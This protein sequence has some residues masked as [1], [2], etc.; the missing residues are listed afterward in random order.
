MITSFVLKTLNRLR[1]EEQ[2]QVLMLGALFIVVMAGAAAMAIDGGSFMSH[3]RSLQ[4]DADAIA[5]AA[6]QGLPSSSDATALANSWAAKNGVD[7]STMTITITPQNLP[8]EPNPKVK[9]DLLAD[10]D[11]TF[12]AVLGLDSAEVSATATAIKTSPGGGDGLMPWSVLE[13][14]MDEAG[15]GESVVLK[16]DANNGSN[17]NFG[18]L[19]LDGNGS[20]VYENSII[21]GSSTSVCAV[22]ATDCVGASVVSTETGNMTGGTRDGTDYRLDNTSSSCDSWNEVVI[23]NADGSHTLNPDCNPFVPGGNPDSLQIIVVPIIDSLCNGACYVSIVEFGLF[24]LEGYGA[25]G[26]TGNNCE[27]EGRFIQTNTNIGALQGTFDPDTFVHF[28]RLV[29]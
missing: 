12:M 8:G 10:H 25:G 1:G 17:G 7:L 11:L 22:S 13:E 21:N 23:V 5:L 28:V 3:R 9:V 27:I 16:Y 6:S 24:F 18:A 26:C 20:N 15:P 2:G 29:E 19:R 14:T 4:N